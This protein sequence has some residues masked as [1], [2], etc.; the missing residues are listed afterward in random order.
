MYSMRGQIE[1]KKTY[2]IP[3]HRDG[4]EPFGELP[5]YAHSRLAVAPREPAG[6]CAVASARRSKQLV[7]MIPIQCTQCVHF[8]Y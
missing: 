5:G 2:D 7:H 1:S 3:I 4:L 6:L 8:V